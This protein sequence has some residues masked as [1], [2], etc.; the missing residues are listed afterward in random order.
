[1]SQKIPNVLRDFVAGTSVHAI[2]G[3]QCRLEVTVHDRRGDAAIV[4]CILVVDA[5]RVSKIRRLKLNRVHLGYI[6]PSK[7]DQLLGDLVGSG[8]LLDLHRENTMTG[9]YKKVQQKSERELVCAPHRVNQA[10]VARRTGRPTAS[11]NT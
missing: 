8:G 1:M 11:S 7:L 5:H 10:A 9:F 6:V 4:A 3:L 2:S